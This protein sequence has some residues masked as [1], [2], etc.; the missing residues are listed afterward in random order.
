M[1]KTLLQEIK[2]Q[3]DCEKYT[4]WN[5]KTCY[6]TWGILAWYLLKCKEY[7][8]TPKQIGDFC[9]LAKGNGYEFEYCE[10]DIIYAID[11]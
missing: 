3:P 4:A 1:K 5:G 11:L 7:R 10:N 2:S 6:K 9:Y 8:L